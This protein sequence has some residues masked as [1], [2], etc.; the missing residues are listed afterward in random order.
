MLYITQKL[1]KQGPRISIIIELSLSVHLMGSILPFT[2]STVVCRCRWARRVQRLGGVGFCSPKM[3]FT[4]FHPWELCGCRCVPPPSPNQHYSLV[5]QRKIVLNVAQTSCVPAQ[6]LSTF[7]PPR[8]SIANCELWFPLLLLY[9][10]T[11]MVCCQ[12]INWEQGIL[13][14]ANTTVSRAWSERE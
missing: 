13:M 11:T 6:K 1:Q 10:V 5:W 7:C 12:D 4:S 8:A 14:G 2:C 9:T 3:G